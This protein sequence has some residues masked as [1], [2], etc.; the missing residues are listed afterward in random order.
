MPKQQ[1]QTGNEF[2][3]GATIAGFSNKM[4]S[5]ALIFLDALLGIIEIRVLLHWIIQVD[6]FFF[7][8]F[9]SENLL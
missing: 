6:I 9:S 2:W 5:P 7:L 3:A 8:N 4:V 1:T